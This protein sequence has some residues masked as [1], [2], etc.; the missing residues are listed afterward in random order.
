MENYLQV[1]ADLLL[2]LLVAKSPEAPAR[3]KELL[4]VQGPQFSVSFQSLWAK[5][6]VTQVHTI[7]RVHLKS[8]KR[9][10]RL[11]SLM[12]PHRKE[13]PE[14]LPGTRGTGGGVSGIGLATPQITINFTSCT[15]KQKSQQEGEILVHLAQG[16]GL[17]NEET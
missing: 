14:E 6:R 9:W 1:Q 8:C 13:Q 11:A 16:L 12:K 3:A 7:T 4:Q 17:K 2:W 15:K 10:Q 5:S